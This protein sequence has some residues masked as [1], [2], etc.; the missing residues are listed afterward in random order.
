MAFSV[1]HSLVEAGQV[2]SRPLVFL[3]YMKTVRLVRGF[4]GRGWTVV[5][6]SRLAR[7]ECSSTYAT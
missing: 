1:L 7:P 4:S 2:Q 6:C 3:D 5:D